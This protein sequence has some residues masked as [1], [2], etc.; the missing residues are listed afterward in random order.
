MATLKGLLH[1][2]IR[3]FSHI[4]SGST[5]KTLSNLL[6]PQ[7][8]PYSKPPSSVNWFIAEAP[9]SIHAWEPKYSLESRNQDM[10]LCCSRPSSSFPSHLKEHPKSLW[11]PHT[12][13]A[14]V[15]F[16]IS[17]L[18]PVLSLVQSHWCS[19]YC[20]NTPNTFVSPF[21]VLIILFLMVF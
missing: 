16:P 18:T 4:S 1:Q 13:F 10:G 20:S 19:C 9:I 7:H 17:F 8:L 14:L 3:N 12:W 11:W 21:F 5:F 6:P 2:D 15:T